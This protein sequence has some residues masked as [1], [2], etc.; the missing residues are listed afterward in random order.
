MKSFEWSLPLFQIYKSVKLL[1]Y[2]ICIF[3]AN[4][5]LCVLKKVS[6]REVRVRHVICSVLRVTAP[7]R[8]LTR[9]GQQVLYFQN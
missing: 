6:P 1:I 2:L 7:A 3:Q 9:P 5:Q 8:A 4:H